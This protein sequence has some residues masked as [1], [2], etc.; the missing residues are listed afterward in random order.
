MTWSGDAR[1][2]ADDMRTALALDPTAV[3][4]L[5]AIGLVLPPRQATAM[6]GQD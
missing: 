4:K 6:A 1:T 2:G 5:A 3:E